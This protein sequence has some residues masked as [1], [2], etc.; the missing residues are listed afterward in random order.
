MNEAAVRHEPWGA[1][2][3]AVGPD[4][5]KVRVRAAR[6]DMRR[7]TAM[8]GPRYAG[9][10][11][12][13]DLA[14][15]PVPGEQHVPLRRVASDELFDYF[16]GVLWEPTRRLQYAFLLD[17]GRTRRWYGE[18]GVA[19]ERAAA[20]TFLLPHLD[21]A[22]PY[23]VPAW[24][25]GA[26]FYEIFPDCFC[27]GDPSND[28]PGTL[29]WDTPPPM[30][31]NAHT[32]FYGGDLKGIVQKVPYLVA[33]GVEAVWLTPIFKSPSA[34][35]YDT[36]D[37][38]QIDPHFGNET[39][40]R[41]LV[42]ALHRRGIRLVLDAVF[43][44]C[45]D[46]FAPFQ[47]VLRRGA[48]GAESPSARWFRIEGFPV[49]QEPKNYET[50]AF[51]P[52]MP[53]LMTRHPE[54]RR[55]LLDVA[56]HWTTLGVDGWRLDVANE[57]D[58]DFWRAFRQAVREVNPATYIVGEIWH[59]AEPWLWGDQF[60]AVMNYPLRSAALDYFAAGAIGPETFDARLANARL[61]YAD[62]VNDALLNL[63]GSHDPPRFL[64]LCGGADPRRRDEAGRKAALATVFLHT[65]PG[66]PMVYYGDEVGMGTHDLD[67][68]APMIWDQARQ[69]AGAFALHRRLIA[70]R[71][72]LP[73][74]RTGGYTTLLA[75]PL[76]NA[77]AFARTAPDDQPDAPTV[78]TAL[79]NRAGH[80]RL[81]LPLA[82]LAPGGTPSQ[83]L[84]FRD[85]LTGT[86]HHTDG[87]HLNVDLAPWQGAVLVQQR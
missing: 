52:R 66:S 20:G 14:G 76:L 22:P 38:L 87:G 58:H 15:R 60:D 85:A 81:R 31:Y 36:E 1:Y 6:G 78:V 2:A 10:G 73:T 45:G 61:A 69:D 57:V 65:Y 74:L 29:A 41:D 16:E 46:R 56:R 18:H 79:H 77:Y 72:N 75:D 42:D 86:V 83:P 68:R 44:H 39:T 53:K 11:G 9:R 33:L 12:V 23:D 13:R 43:N 80:H 27:N 19:A 30:P 8:H 54:V 62:P 51:T 25:R 4:R 55:Y 3:F 63:L 32:T 47:D 21:A 49:R 70:L 7:V 37:Y 34:H 50:F 71:R 64:T 35:K 40:F 59:R 5:L 82:A 48:R 28:P 67:R 24:A 26:V 84:E 17:D